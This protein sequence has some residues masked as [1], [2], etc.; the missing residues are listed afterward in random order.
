M[1][2]TTNN[3]NSTEQQIVNDIT[4][5]IVRYLFSQYLNV[6]DQ[7]IGFR[8]TNFK[9]MM[10]VFCQ[11]HFI[12]SFDGKTKEE[13]G[14][15]SS[16]IQ[17]SVNEECDKIMSNRSITDLPTKQIFDE[18]D[19][20]NSIYF[21]I[22]VS[23]LNSY[24]HEDYFSHFFEYNASNQTPSIS[25]YLDSNRSFIKQRAIERLDTLCINFKIDDIDK[26]I[27]TKKLDKYYSISL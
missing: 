20:L 13:I 21:D 22:T 27:L 4:K 16:I 8:W 12:K 1:I 15:I 3:T 10:N 11:K 14:D 9:E 2:I 26:Q 6:S 19:L 18:V 5:Q 17:N 7:P 25:H 23:L 24:Y